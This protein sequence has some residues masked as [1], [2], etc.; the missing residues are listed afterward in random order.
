[1]QHVT[2]PDHAS[3]RAHNLKHVKQEP[4][5]GDV[6]IKEDKVETKQEDDKS[7]LPR[8]WTWSRGKCQHMRLESDLAKKTRLGST[9]KPVFLEFVKYAHLGECRL[10]DPI[11]HH[12]ITPLR[13]GDDWL[14]K[15]L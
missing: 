3:K 12:V 11:R 14:M 15:H 7:R 9:L 8:S 6:P 1:M 2:G 4:K 10:N 5:V 13:P